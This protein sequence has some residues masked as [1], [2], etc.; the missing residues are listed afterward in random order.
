MSPSL[1]APPVSSA[2]IS[3]KPLNARGVDRVI[4]VD[5]MSK[6]DKFRNLVDCNIVDYLDKN[7]FLDL[8]M[9]G[10]FDGDVEAIFHEGAPAR[11]RWKPTAAT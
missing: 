2:P 4:A 5:N 6:A 7:D 8:V 11:T 1:P 10:H 3:S 9:S